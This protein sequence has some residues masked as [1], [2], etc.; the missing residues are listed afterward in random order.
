ML[1]LIASDIDGTLMPYGQKELPPALFGLI[2]R[3]RSVGILFCPTSGRQYHSMRTLFAPVA[4][5]VCFLCENGGFI[6]GPG[7]EYGAPVLSK[8][9]M[10]RPDA[11]ALAHAIMELPECEVL[12]SGQNVSYVCGCGEDFVR[13]MEDVHGNLVARVDR[14]EDITED[15]LKVTAF[16]PNGLD[17]PA[18]TLGP[19]W[20][21]RYH[22]AEAGPVWLDF[23]LADKGSGLRGLCRALGIEP[24]EAAAFGDN[25]NDV[26]MLEMVGMPWLMASAA[27]ALRERFPR[28]C[29]DV[30]E[31]LESMLREVELRNGR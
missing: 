29:A 12:I 4:D 21:G 7:E 17:G 1:K 3:L 22:M 30:P 19:R 8:T 16:C 15:I 5:E 28:Q 2:R 10:P 6:F 31:T 18:A 9:A 14:V 27:P 26:S 23:G 20:G 13:R 24:A 11:L 25:W